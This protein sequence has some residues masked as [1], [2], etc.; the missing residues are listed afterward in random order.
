M[1]AFNISY[2]SIKNKYIS[3]FF[4]ALHFSVTAISHCWLDAIS[5]TITI[6][7]VYLVRTF[8]CYIFT[9]LA[10]RCNFHAVSHL[11]LVVCTVLTALPSSFHILSEWCLLKKRRN[12]YR[13]LGNS[14]FKSL[15][16]AHCWKSLTKQTMQGKKT[17][18]KKDINYIY[19]WI[20]PTSGQVEPLLLRF[21]TKEFLLCIFKWF[22]NTSLN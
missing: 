7:P 22:S 14:A 3:G 17:T 18:T 5:N 2:K 12:K 16:Q 11:E 13:L 8:P 21:Y 1:L 20:L 15:H 4:L 6:H 9:D 10:Q 19:V